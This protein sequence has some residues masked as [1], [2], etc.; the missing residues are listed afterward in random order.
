[1]QCPK[2]A[3]EIEAA[4]DLESVR[5]RRLCTLQYEL[6]ADGL[7]YSLLYLPEVTGFQKRGVFALI[8]EDIHRK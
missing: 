2:K 3:V 4:S 5:K 7:Q 1:M 6:G 8:V